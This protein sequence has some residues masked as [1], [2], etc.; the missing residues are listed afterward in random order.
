MGK[1]AWYLTL[2]LVIAGAIQLGR[3]LN[4]MIFPKF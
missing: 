3:L 2:L 4:K 1:V